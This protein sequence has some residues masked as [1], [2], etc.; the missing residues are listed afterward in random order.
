MNENLEVPGSSS[1]SE[2][3]WAEIF[4]F[5]CWRSF[6]NIMSG[7]NPQGQAT[8]G[9]ELSWESLMK[10]KKPELKS[11]RW[12]FVIWS[13]PTPAGRSCASS[14]QHPSQNPSS[15]AAPL[16]AGS[17]SGLYDQWR[18]NSLPRFPWRWEQAVNINLLSKGIWHLSLGAA[19]CVGTKCKPDYFPFCWSL[20]SV[21]ML[22]LKWQ[23]LVFIHFCFHSQFL[24]GLY[25]LQNTFLWN[26]ND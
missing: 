18:Q 13:Y 25:Y 8:S 11:Q 24:F 10:G 17:A 12:S 26:Y 2:S 19:Q 15:W 3:S 20:C 4:A 9:A 5:R 6:R 1:E 16:P 14:L 7:P 22:W 23:P 21:L